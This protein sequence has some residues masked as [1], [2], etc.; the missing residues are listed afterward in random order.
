M[1]NKFIKIIEAPET[2]PI[3]YEDVSA[4]MRL[5]NEDE[6]SYI[7]GFVIPAVVD[8][9]EQYLN[10]KFITQK[11]QMIL[12]YF[13]SNEII[14]PWP[15]LQSVEFVK[16]LDLVGNEIEYDANKYI[17][18]RAIG[19]VAYSQHRFGA[20]ELVSG[21][22]WPQAKDTWDA[23]KI[24]FICGYG[25]DGESV[26]AVLRVAMLQLCA[27]W[28]NNREILAADFSVPNIIPIG[29]N[30]ILWQ[31]GLGDS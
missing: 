15:P 10:K 8:Y 5:S 3:T 21:E 2:T 25:D 26:P 18:K 29:I 6:K 16:Y 1:L 28:I 17:V 4:H 31:H 22:S 19:D 7:E 13:P 24:E 20:I 30:N 27:H 14:L 12:N 23:V 9:C 11:W